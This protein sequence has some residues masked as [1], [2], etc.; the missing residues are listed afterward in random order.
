MPIQN[1][2]LGLLS[3]RSF[4]GYELKKIFADSAIFYWSGNNNQIYKALV[5]LHAEGLVTQ[6]VEYQEN[7]PARKIYTITDKGR[8]VLKS[9]VLST[10]ELP[11]YHNTFLVQ[12]AWADTLSPKE[13]DELLAAYEEEVQIQMHM[14]Q[15]NTR[16]KEAAPARTP[17]ET[18]LWGMISQN[19]ISI[20]ENEL[21]WVRQLRARL[22]QF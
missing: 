12:L 6:Q 7:L 19:V 1:A 11:E 15:E 18:Y 17:R 4:T 10:P 16:R 8:E 9:W 20:Y 3:W 22:K 5:Y 2:I 13:L 14:Q 21:D